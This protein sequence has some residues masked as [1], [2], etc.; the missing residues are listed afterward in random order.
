MNESGAGMKRRVMIRVID[1]KWHDDSKT[2]GSR[3]TSILEF[4]T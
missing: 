3:E 1:N 4:I 2:V